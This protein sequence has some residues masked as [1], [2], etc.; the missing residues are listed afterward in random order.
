M[1]THFCFSELLI[2]REKK[3]RGFSFRPL[4]YK[5]ITNF[6][7]TLKKHH[8]GALHKK[9][10]QFFT[11]RRKSSFFLTHPVFL[12]ETEYKVIIQGKLI[13]VAYTFRTY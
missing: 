5:K 3:I 8:T 1:N 4:E 11:R 7:K 12:K 10:T 6:Q 9:K 2:L 13:A